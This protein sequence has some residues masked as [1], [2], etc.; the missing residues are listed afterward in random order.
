MTFDR[1]VILEKA[2]LCFDREI[3]ALRTTSEGLDDSFVAV[4]E[5]IQSTIRHGGK[6]IFTG[7][8]KNTP[9]GAKLTATFNSTGVPAH[10]L[11]PNNALH[12]DLGICREGDL[13]FFISN[14]GETED[15]L[16]LVPLVQ[17]FG[18]STVALTRSADSTLARTVDHVLLYRVEREACPLN[19]A[20]T[21]STAAALALGDALAM[22]FL[23]VR[24]F[25]R[26]DF[27]RFHPAGTL[28]KYLLLRVREIM[29]T[30]ERF[31]CGAASSSVR[32][33]LMD[34]TR[35]RCGTIA[36]TGADGTLA[37]VFSDGDFRRASLND[38]TIL[39]REVEEVMTRNP[40]TVEAEALAVDA[41][42]IFE[43]NK[44]NDLVA[45]DSENRPVGLLDGQDLPQLKI[46]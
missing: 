44:V 4:L 14:N 43:H 45:V 1:K 29:R 10:F 11:D 23:E 37:G 18:C 36:L 12:G 7:V 35:A 24:G 41:L 6:L 40:V 26:E 2:R 34:M 19:L 33:A 28:G 22:V 42:R 13:A 25:T 5:C 20:P 16:R 21:A 38:E 17:R 32:D 39:Q 3:A 31:A 46:I 9:L 27:A 15:L 30:G 8:G